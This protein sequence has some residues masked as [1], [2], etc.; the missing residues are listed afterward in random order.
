[1]DIINGQ[2]VRLTKGDFTTKKIY[3]NDPVAVAKRFEDIG[4]RRLHMVDLDGARIKKVKNI[5]VLEDVAGQTNLSIDFGGGVQ[6]NEDIRRVFNAGAAQIT[7]GSVSIKNP[8]LVESW[9]Q[10]YGKEKIILGADI[11]DKM[12]AISGWQ[13]ATSL[14]IDQYIQDNIKKGF[15]YVICTDI[16]RDGM[17]EGPAIDLYSE[18]KGRYTPIYLIASGGV[19]K[20]DDIERLA[21]SGVDA[22]IIGKALYEGRIELKELKPYLC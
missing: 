10:K 7:A 8:S 17:L 3:D 1:M 18:L 4:V 9:L 16:S 6:S 11:K 15:K 2:C 14:D 20:I 22:A 21:D 19:G 12:I 13:E 5:S